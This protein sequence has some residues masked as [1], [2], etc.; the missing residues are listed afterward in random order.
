MEVMVAALT[1]DVE[2]RE[3]DVLEEGED[4]VQQ[5][6]QLELADEAVAVVVEER[7]QVA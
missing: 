5:L 7:E 2:P 1:V 3:P 4:G 6:D